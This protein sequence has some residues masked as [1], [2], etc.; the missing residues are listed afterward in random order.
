MPEVM[1]R[2]PNQHHPKQQIHQD[3]NKKWEP[4]AASAHPFLQDTVNYR[5]LTVIKERETGFEPATS[6]LGRTTKNK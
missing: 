6:T 3:L 1:V 5:S 2:Q 4:P